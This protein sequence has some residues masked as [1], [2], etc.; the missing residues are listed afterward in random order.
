MKEIIAE[1]CWRW[2]KCKLTII[3]YVYQKNV[4]QDQ[5]ENQENMSKSMWLT[6][7]GG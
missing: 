6:E 5:V 7:S 1:S 2:K 4:K 3:Y